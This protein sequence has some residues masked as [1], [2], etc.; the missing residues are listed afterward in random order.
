[1]TIIEYKDW[2]KFKVRQDSDGAD[3]I[4]KIRRL[5]TLYYNTENGVISSKSGKTYF[6]VQES[7]R[8]RV[9]E[10]IKNTL[11]ESKKTQ[12]PEKV[13]IKYFEGIK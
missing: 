5:V 11:N 8:D 3:S 7:D 9:Y 6:T 4:K 1:M 13:L 12:I 10:N 2:V